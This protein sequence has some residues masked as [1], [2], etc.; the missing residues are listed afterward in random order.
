MRF[1]IGSTIRG[2]RATVTV[3]CRMEAA[4]VAGGSNH[5]A[6]S[7]MWSDC[8]TWG[9]REGVACRSVGTELTLL[10]LAQQDHL[11]LVLDDHGILFFFL[12]NLLCTWSK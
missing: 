4:R 3:I 2:H 5:P 1:L 6:V 9:P 12:P 7:Q 11:T 8:T 10:L